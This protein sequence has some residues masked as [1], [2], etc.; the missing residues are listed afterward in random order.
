MKLKTI[1]LFAIFVM[2]ISSISVMAEETTQGT[3]QFS[4]SVNDYPDHKDYDLSKNIPNAYVNMYTVTLDGNAFKVIDFETK[5]TGAS[6][7]AKFNLELDQ[8][9]YFEGFKTYA[10]ALDG[11]ANKQALKWTAPP[12]KNFGTGSN[13]LCQ[14]HWTKT[15]EFLQYSE[16]Y[17]CAQSLSTPYQDTSIETP[18]LITSPEE[19]VE[20]DLTIASLTAGEEGFKAKVCNLGDTDLSGF[21][22]K[23]DTNGKENI[24]TY[25][26]TLTDGNCV[27]IGSWGY[28]YFGLTKDNL[29]DAK[30]IVDPS[31]TLSE[32][33]E[34][35]NIGYF[36]FDQKDKTAQYLI[37]TWDGEETVR[38]NVGKYLVDPSNH[39]KAKLVE[40]KPAKLTT[41]YKGENTYTAKFDVKENEIV[42]FVSLEYTLDLPKTIDNVKNFPGSHKVFVNNGLKDKS[43]E[44]TLCKYNSK[45]CSFSG[46]GQQILFAEDLPSALF[47]PKMAMPIIPK[48]TNGM[49][50]AYDENKW[51]PITQELICNEGCKHEN[52]CLPVGTKIKENQ[53][54]L[55]CDW[56]SEMK[57]Q[58]R[59]GNSCQNNYEC[60]SNSCISGN[61]LDLE[62]K[63]Q[64]QDD[65][66]QKL[67]DWFNNFFGRS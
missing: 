41:D 30:V 28:G 53:K 47:I 48:V 51:N 62:K 31:N 22:I 49:L 10:G 66:I 20:T 21:Q 42:A 57:P 37:W 26:P 50:P 5:N 56:D 7:T 43:G 60:A 11:A 2:F 33:N 55:Y 44:Y 16:D 34:E 18:V 23:F 36:N 25:A 46:S 39:Y 61:C 19:S 63:L 67:M 15:N 65:L 14:T 12:Y 45:S 52:K 40:T 8:M 29:V 38:A 32:S 4:V 13:Q 6:A 9:V 64:E 59:E 54:G 1:A 3:T 27:T 24:L 17:A 58:L 35:N